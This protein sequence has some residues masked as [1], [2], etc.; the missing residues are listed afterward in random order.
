M[1]ASFLDSDSFFENEVESD[2]EQN[3]RTTKKAPRGAPFVRRSRSGGLARIV[4]LELDRVRGHFEAGDFGHLQL[5]ISVD[6][7]VVEHAAVLEEAAVLVE[8]FERLAQAAAHRRDL[9]QLFL[10]QIVEV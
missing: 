5:D 3:S 6:E 10:R 2:A 4:H 1:R 8:V 9:L 7:V